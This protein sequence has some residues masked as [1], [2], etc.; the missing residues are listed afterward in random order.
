MSSMIKIGGGGSIILLVDFIWNDPICNMYS[1]FNKIV[2]TFAKI[3]K[4]VDFLTKVRI[5]LCYCI[6]YRDALVLYL[7]NFDQIWSKIIL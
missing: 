5:A 6:Y 4:R 2:H 3:I 1:Q 7:P